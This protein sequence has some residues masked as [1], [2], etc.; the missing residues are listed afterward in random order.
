MIE[1]GDLCFV[2]ASP[3]NPREWEY[4]LSQGEALRNFQAFASRVGFIGHSH[5]PVLIELWRGRVECPEL[6]PR[7]LLDDRRY[8]VN[9]GSVGQPRDHDPRLCYVE[10]DARL[11]RVAFRRLEYPVRETQEA[12]RKTD[13]PV[14]LAER[15]EHG[16]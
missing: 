3:R 2:H 4:V 15:L 9:V 13:L 14:Q 8:M 7:E 1:E 5:Q 6:G 11:G 12:I 10:V 16:W